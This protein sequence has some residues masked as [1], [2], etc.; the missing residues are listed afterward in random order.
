LRQVFKFSK[1]GGKYGDLVICTLRSVID[2]VRVGAQLL[3]LLW[4]ALEKGAMRSFHRVLCGFYGWGV[5]VRI[6]TTDDILI[7]FTSFIVGPMISATKG[8][9]C[10]DFPT[11]LAFC[12][13]VL[14]IAFDA[15]VWPV[16]VAS[17][18]PVLLTACA[19]WDVVFICSKWFNVY[20]FIL[21][22]RNFINFFVVLGWFKIDEQQV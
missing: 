17:R 18:M 7:V 8:A 20:D 14:A 3:G 19:L 4:G 10:W 13:I 16:V 11:F 12:T 21:Y 15:R 5:S 2:Y 6:S 22:G 1:E 9:F